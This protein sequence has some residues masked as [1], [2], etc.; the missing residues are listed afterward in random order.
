I[1]LWDLT[2]SGS[3]DLISLAGE[4][5][6]KAAYKAIVRSIDQQFPE[7]EI[8]LLLLP[9]GGSGQVV[10]GL[11]NNSVAHLRA[12]PSSKTEM[13]NQALLGTPVRILK[14]EDGWYLVQTPNQYLGWVNDSEI[15]SIDETE[16]TG[17]REAQKI[18][19]TEQYGFSFTE[20]DE[21]S[22]PVSDLVIGCL[23]PII[24][25]E[26]D[27]YKVEYPDRRLAWVKK[28]EAIQA[29]HLFNKTL[30]QEELVKTAL[31]FNGIPYLWGGTSSKA[32]DCSGLSSLSFFLNGTLLPRD[33][34]QQSQCGRV[35]TTDYD[36]QEL[37]T[38]DLL[39]FGRKATDTRPEN[40]SHI[41]IYLGDSE[42][43][44]AA[45]YRDRVS[46]NSMDST[47]ENFIESYPEIFVRAVRI[48]G[49][50]G[51]G[52]QPIAENSFYK[53]IISIAD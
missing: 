36:H 11:V 26:S 10:N 40:V 28:D 39:F 45:G 4:V 2:V 49:E 12:K 3:K 46:I 23:L 19:Y 48:I 22:M 18:I 6:D 44:H 24:S 32:I 47:R 43:I 15:Q 7:V 30:Q 8:T 37:V 5:D 16:L 50:T 38:G 1:A 42:F 20:P 53:E 14:E 51:D 33:T 35:V 41:A 29:E 52:F 17:F 13:I 9:E 25:D 21:T 27:F 31:N 34:D